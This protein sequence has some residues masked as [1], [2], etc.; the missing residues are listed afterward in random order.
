MFWGFTS[1]AIPFGVFGPGLTVGVILARLYGEFVIRVFALQTTANV[2][3]A[4]GF[5][6][7][8]CGLTRS[9]APMV[10]ILEMTGEMSLILPILITSM[11]GFLFSSIFNIG[12]FEMIISIRKLPYLPTFMPP[13]RGATPIGEIY[14]P[15]GSDFIHDDANLYDMFE[16]LIGKTEVNSKEFFPIINRESKRIKAYVRA[17]DCVQYMRASVVD[18]E[19]IIMEHRP[20][21]SHQIYKNLATFVRDHGTDAE[22]IISKRIWNHLRKI[23]LKTNRFEIGQFGTS[24]VKARPEAHSEAHLLHTPS[25][26]VRF[27]ERASTT[28]ELDCRMKEKARQEERE[29]NKKITMELLSRVSVDFDS[30]VL[31]VNPVPIMA[32]TNVTAT[33]IHFIFL[34]LGVPVVWVQNCDSQLLGKI[35]LDAFLTFKSA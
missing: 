7:F 6:A 27:S 9:F 29:V 15:L 13:G 2:F 33:K 28:F 31:R 23:K 35:T 12:F 4:C 21:L 26:D 11:I 25:Q 8:L 18:V 5:A 1:S 24:V 10:C 20:K 22:K 3:A 32:S 16:L 30:P 14:E 17:E 19:A 34:M